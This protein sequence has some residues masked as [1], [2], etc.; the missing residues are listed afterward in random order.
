MLS[1]VKPPEFVGVGTPLKMHFRALL[2]KGPG[3]ASVPV[4]VTFS[5]GTLRNIETENGAEQPCCAL[6]ADGRKTHAMPN[7]VTEKRALLKLL[8]VCCTFIKPAFSL[9]ERNGGL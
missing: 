9:R 6:T 1:M 2:S 7:R 5:V 8:S 4:S 3:T